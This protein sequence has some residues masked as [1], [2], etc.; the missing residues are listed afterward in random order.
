MASLFGFRRIL[1]VD[2][3]SRLEVFFKIPQNSQENICTGV[4]FLI[5]LQPAGLQLYQKRRSNKF[6][7]PVN[8]AKFLKNLF[9]IESLQTA[10]SVRLEAFLVSSKILYFPVFH[11]SWNLTFLNYCE[12]DVMKS[13]EACITLGPSIAPPSTVET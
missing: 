6:Y 11:Q 5:K 7:F 8:F 4:S 3:S 9:F 2:R 13:N 10:A 12:V 1:G